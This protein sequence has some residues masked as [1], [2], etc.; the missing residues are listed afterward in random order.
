[1]RSSSLGAPTG[2]QHVVVA[3][4]FRR[5]P[6][7]Q[8]GDQRHP[9][10]LR[11]GGPCRDGLVHGG[12]PDQ[13]RTQG[14]QHPYL[15]RGLVV[16]AGH[17]R[18]DALAQRGVGLQGQLAQPRRVGVDQVDEYRSDHRGAGSQIEVVTDQ[19]RLPDP[20]FGVQTP[21]GVGQHDDVRAGGA[22]GT[23]RVDDPAEVVAFVGVDAAEE[24]QNPEITDRY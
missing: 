19:H 17:G 1:M 16:R 22:G 14:A 8:I 21:G 4:R 9:E 12:H 2:C 20:V 10:H 5:H 23:H 11:A 6:G 24:H 15:G 3:H 18:I 7:R 13:V